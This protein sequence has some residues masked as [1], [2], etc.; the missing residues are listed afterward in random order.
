[1]F[2]LAYLCSREVVGGIALCREEGVFRAVRE[3]LVVL[4]VYLHNDVPDYE[5][6]F[7]LPYL[8]VEFVLDGVSLKELCKNSFGA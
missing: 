8:L 1:M 3:V 5:I 7:V 4:P 6:Q 2:A